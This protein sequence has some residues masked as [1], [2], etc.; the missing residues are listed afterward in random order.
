MFVSK[1]GRVQVL[2]EAQIPGSLVKLL[3]GEGG[4]DQLGKTI[5]ATSIGGRYTA[6]AHAA[7]FM[8]LE[9]PRDGKSEYRLVS[10]GSDAATDGE[11]ITALYCMDIYTPAHKSSPAVC[12]IAGYSSGYMRVFSA[13]G[14]LLTAH[15]FHP[16]RLQ[17]IRLRTPAQANSEQ[18]AHKLQ[19]SS[20]AD[21]RAASDDSEEVNLTYRDGTLVSIDG[22][23]LYLALRLCLEEA[24]I[25]E[26]PTFQ[27]KKWAFDLGTPRVSDAAACGP[28]LWRD[29]LAQ[30]VRGAHASSAQLADAT[31]RFLV[32]PQNGDAA[33]GVFTTSEDAAATFSAV[34]IAG[35]MAARVT[36]AVL[37]MARSYLWRGGSGELSGQASPGRTE[38]STMVSCALA[39][40]DSP[41]K[42]LHIALAPA[43]YALAALTDSLGRVL[44]LDLDSCEVVHM[45]KG[46]R[47][48]QCAWLEST[49][50][51]RRCLLVA[52]YTARRGVLEIYEPGAMQPLDSVNVGAGWTLV[53]CPTQPLGGSLVVGPAGHERR[54][55]LP[56]PAACVL[57][58]HDG[59]I[60]LITVDER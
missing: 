53:Q 45:L 31:A 44:L 26:G 19:Y 23:S 1:N 41:R 51:G 59:R 13:H 20:C 36:G 4:G 8:L 22:R 60:A 39:V 25:D 32:A 6:L 50:D 35:K 37:S 47:G 17:C 14:H 42:V 11:A 34:D 30:L 12:V 28:P 18:S 33:F 58:G 15:Q 27:Y 24:A 3:L 40:R 16:Q 49:C 5:C 9:I 29:P 10:V 43:Q 46:V 2:A 56:A 38:P 54:A 48:C 52:V 55:A 21:P 57:L 7:R